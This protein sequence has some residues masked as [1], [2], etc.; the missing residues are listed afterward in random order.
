MATGRPCTRRNKLVSSND[1]S[2]LRCSTDGIARLQSST[3]LRNMFF[4]PAK[5][6]AR[7]VNRHVQ[8]STSDYLFRFYY[9][10][11]ITSLIIITHVPVS[12]SFPFTTASTAY[13]RPP[14][15]RSSS[16]RARE[17]SGGEGCRRVDRTPGRW[18]NRSP[19]MSRHLY[20]CWPDCRW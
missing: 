19:G 16:L 8:I 4:F 7:C 1:P 13:P 2:T 17:V 18:C 3:L 14:A 15:P 12:F 6:F 10:H 9:R 11:Y 20:D 5:F